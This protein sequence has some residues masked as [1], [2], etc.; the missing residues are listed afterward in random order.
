MA[1]FLKFKEI[2]PTEFPKFNTTA[3][4]VCSLIAVHLAHAITSL[5]ES[6]RISIICIL[7]IESDLQAFEQ[8]KDPLILIGGQDN[9]IF[10]ISLLLMFFY[11][12]SF[13]SA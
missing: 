5:A 13:A 12:N 1:T 3:L 7:I 6:N 11:A 2:F 4:C 10:M 9:Y 8:Q